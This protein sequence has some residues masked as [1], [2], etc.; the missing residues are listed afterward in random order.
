MLALK[1]LINVLKRQLLVG[2][3]AVVVFHY[4]TIL[5]VLNSLVARMR[6]LSHSVDPFAS[7]T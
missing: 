2:E 4:P 6:L 3:Y 7:M 5:L 1:N